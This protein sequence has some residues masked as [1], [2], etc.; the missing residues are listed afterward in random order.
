MGNILACKLL[1]LMALLAGIIV[2][3]RFVVDADAQNGIAW[4]WM[5][6]L[7]AFLSVTHGLEAFYLHIFLPSDNRLAVRCGLYPLLMFAGSH[8][9]KYLAKKYRGPRPP[10]VRLIPSIMFQF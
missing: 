9:V 3:C 5:A 7:S 4:F 2:F 10:A 6:L 1:E 8:I